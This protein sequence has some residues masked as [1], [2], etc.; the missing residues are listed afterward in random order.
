M[1]ASSGQGSNIEPG[2]IRVIHTRQQ[3]FNQAAASGHINRAWAPVHAA[4]IELLAMERREERRGGRL[5]KR[6]A[7]CWQATMAPGV[8]GVGL[9]RLNDERVETD[10]MTQAPPSRD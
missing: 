1:H 4:C 6:S 10:P 5:E 9:S 7:R 2:A 3:Q 8:P